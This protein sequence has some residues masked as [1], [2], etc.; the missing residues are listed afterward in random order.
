MN[1][2]ILAFAAVL[3]FGCRSAEHMA[4][5]RA[6]KARDKAEKYLAKAIIA[7]PSILTTETRVDTVVMYT[8]PTAIAGGRMYTQQSMDS[9]STICA[10]LLHTYRN[11]ADE[12]IRSK[13]SKVFRQRVCGFAPVDTVDGPCAI[14]IWEDGGRIAWFHNKAAERVEATVEN[15]Q[16]SVSI[17]TEQPKGRTK[18]MG[19]AWTVV[20]GVVCFAFGV[21]FAGFM[22]GSHRHEQ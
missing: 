3:L 12:A 10:D 11:Q 2:T 15:T 4:A 18:G 7:D 22:K 19:R 20:I 6:D 21:L 14:R 8:E 5:I 16:R 17:T 1:P 13:A 9:L